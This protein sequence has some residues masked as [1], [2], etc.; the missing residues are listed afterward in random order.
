MGYDGEFFDSL[1]AADGGEPWGYWDSEYEQ[2]KAE[3]PLAALRD[4]RPPE[5]VDRILDLGCGNGAKTRLVAEAYPDAEV[6]G[7]DLSAE[8][9]AVAR[10]RTTGVTYERAN[11]VDYVADVDRPFDAIVAVG[12][13]HYLCPERSVTDL[14]ASAETLRDAIAPDG[15]LLAAHNHMPP[16]DGPTFVQERS[17]RTLRHVL[18]TAFETVGRSRYVE[19][20]QVALDPDEPA[21]Q[22][23]E[24]WAMRPEATSR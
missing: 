9:L 13:L 8:A 1:Y 20:K 19:S 15:L 12:A 11:M 24:V 21:E 6:V 23:Y 3:R 16:G 10:E 2:R 18:E 22:P 14:L 7:V 4:R 5:D 17:V